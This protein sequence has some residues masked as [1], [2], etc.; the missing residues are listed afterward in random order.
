M[1]DFKSFVSGVPG[2]KL[3]KQGE[4]GVASHVL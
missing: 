2:H 1:Q 3:D 4:H